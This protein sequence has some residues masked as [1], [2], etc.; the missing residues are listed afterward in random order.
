MAEVSRVRAKAALPNKSATAIALAPMMQRTDRH[1]RY[2]LRLLAPDLRLYTEMITAQA[3][4]HSDPEALLQFDCSEHPLA[5]QLGGSNPEILAKAALI[6]AEFG[7]DEINLNIG[8]PS[9]RV[10]SG[11]F[12]ACLMARP[13]R[14]AECVAAMTAVVDIPI[15]VKTRCGIDD[16]DSYEFVADFIATVSRAGCQFFILHARKAILGGLSPKENRTIPPLRYPLVYQ[17]AEDF[18]ELRMLINGGI[19]DLADVRRHLRR[20]DGVMI[21]R[22]AYSEPYLLAELQES[23]LNDI[24]RRSWRAPVRSE[25][26]EQMARYAA[27]EIDAGVRLHHIT[28]HMLGLYAGQPGARS[29]RRYLSTHAGQA[30]ASTDLLLQSLQYVEVA[31]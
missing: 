10:A 3:L 13:E 22:Q 26:V 18:P 6:G 2:L 21:G 24:C 15:S 4:L 8:C 9:D 30:G 7:F 12:G 27:R 31:K 16:H 17:L 20:V 25:V 14:V 19:R 28:R 1:F 23:V 29:W 5:L 11:D